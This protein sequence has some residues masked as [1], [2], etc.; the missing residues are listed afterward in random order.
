M[1]KEESRS[2]MSR[3]EAGRKRGEA[4]KGSEKHYTPESKERL[5]EG[6]RKGSEH[7]GGGSSERN[8]NEESEEKM[9]EG[10][11]KGGQQ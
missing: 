4:S 1:P 10:G 2:G 11:R 9:R 7:S 8:N 3:E 6:A 5:R